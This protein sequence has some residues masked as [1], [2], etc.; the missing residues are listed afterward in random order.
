MKWLLFLLPFLLFG[1][2]HT[3]PTVVPEYILIEVE[4][5]D[6]DRLEP[7]RALPVVFV[8]ARTDDGFIVLGLRGDQYSNLAIIMRDTMRYIEDQQIAIEYYKKCIADHNAIQLNEEG[9]PE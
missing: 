9:E 1:C 6:F 3:P 4:C 7:V 5:A 8:K 2:K